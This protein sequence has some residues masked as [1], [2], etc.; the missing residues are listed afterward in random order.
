MTATTDID[1][2][3]EAA[4]A[5]DAGVT[6]NGPAEVAP[7]PRKPSVVDP[8]APHGR[9]EDGT[10]FAPHGLKADGTPR[11]K[12]AGPGRPKRDP[13]AAART[14]KASPAATAA[15]GTG[16]DYSRDLDDL[17]DGAWM[18]LSGIP[19]PGALRVKLN[20][21]A[22]L[23]R[24]SK[25]SLVHAGNIAAQ[26]HAGTAQLIEKLTT[27]NAAWALPCM[28]ALGPFVAQSIQLWRTPA[29]QLAALAEQNAAEFRT[30]LTAAAVQ[31][32]EA[33]AA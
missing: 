21:Q 15:P 29:D 25:E 24:G 33:A 9:A 8:E 28:F 20:A 23:L 7:P 19:A 2:A 3:F 4:L 14:A 16:R 10:P 22:A 1:A 30:V 5:A 6:D 17:A 18:L 27:G 32:A 12:P 31:G 13:D 26:H 11:L